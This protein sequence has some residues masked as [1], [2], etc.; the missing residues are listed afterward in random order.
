MMLKRGEKK[1]EDR[2]STKKLGS[3]IGNREDILRRKQRSTA[4]LHNLNSIWIRKNRIREH[5][6]VKL[7]KTVI[8]KTVL[9]Y[10]S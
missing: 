9:M 1:N 6:Q 4:A 10:N 8:K 2:R 3:L 7:Y 5:V